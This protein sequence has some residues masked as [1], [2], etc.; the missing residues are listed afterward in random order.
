[1]DAQRLIRAAGTALVVAMASAAWAWHDCM[2]FAASFVLGLRVFLV[3]M[4][5]GTP[6]LALSA[7]LSSLTAGVLAGVAGLALVAG[8]GAIQLG[9]WIPFAEHPAL[10]LAFLLASATWCCLARHNPHGIA[11]ELR[12]WGLLLAAALVAMQAR[13]SGIEMAPC[14]FVVGVGIALL[15]AGWQLAGDTTSA[16]LRASGEP[17]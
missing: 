16:L 5:H 17:R 2:L 6:W 15:R 3:R 4:D 9:W 12:L 11:E 10:T 14:I 13:G 8:V 1:M 7:A